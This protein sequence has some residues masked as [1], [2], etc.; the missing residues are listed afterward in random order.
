MET[1]GAGVVFPLGD[2]P[3][4]DDLKYEG[5]AL[6]SLA[7][8][9]PAIQGFVRLVFST[10][11]LLDHEFPQVLEEFISNNFEPNTKITNLADRK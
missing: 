4:P 11:H 8:L 5:E 1:L 10:N 6:H 3:D 7:C 9:Y 2:V